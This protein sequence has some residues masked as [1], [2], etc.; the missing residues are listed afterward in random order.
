MIRFHSALADL[1]VPKDFIQPHPD[2]DNNGDVDELITSIMI[3]GCYRP[4]YYQESTQYILAGHTLYA[5]LLEL[6]ALMVP[7]LPL[8]DDGTPNS[9]ERI[10]LTDNQIARLA[11]RDDAA[12]LN[13]LERLNEREN[14]LL[15]TGFNERDVENLRAISEHS[16]GPLN[17]DGMKGQESL[18]H[19]IKCPKC[20]YEWTRGH[21]TEEDP[22]D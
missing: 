18:T 7:A 13:L 3:N 6:G 21:E 12:T 15:G 16:M 11:R 19:R 17:W 9:G 14:G 2:N 20:E 8:D 5:A 4:I 10:L 1:M 22:N